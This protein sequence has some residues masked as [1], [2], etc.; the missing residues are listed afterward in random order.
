MQGHDIL[1]RLGEDAQD[2]VDGHGLCE[3]R[4]EARGPRELDV[5]ARPMPV[6]A[7]SRKSLAHGSARSATAS[8]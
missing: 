1:P 8:W 3:V 6:T 4:L 2:V 7:T 5:G